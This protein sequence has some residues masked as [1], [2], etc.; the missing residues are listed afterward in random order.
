MPTI[1]VVLQDLKVILLEKHYKRRKPPREKKQKA[2][3][4]VPCKIVKVGQPSL[5]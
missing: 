2:L 4:K 3:A 1:D 5:F